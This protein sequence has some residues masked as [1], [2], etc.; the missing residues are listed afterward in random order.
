MEP[1]LNEQYLLE[2]SLH[3]KRMALLTISSVPAAAVSKVV[4]VLNSW[5]LRVMNEPKFK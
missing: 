2:N 5:K 4:L 1:Y 3:P